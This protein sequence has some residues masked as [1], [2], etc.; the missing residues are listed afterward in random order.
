MKGEVRLTGLICRYQEEGAPP[1][2]TAFASTTPAAAPAVTTTQQEAK[3]TAG[4]HKRRQDGHQPELPLVT[5]TPGI[6]AGA[7]QTNI[8]GQNLDIPTFQRR[9]IILDVGD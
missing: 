9:G 7:Q 1:S 6:F 2:P 4:L 3:R 5:Q 8:G